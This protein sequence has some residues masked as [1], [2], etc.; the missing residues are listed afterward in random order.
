MTWEK[1]ERRRGSLKPEVTC[2]IKN[3][4]FGYTC[5]EMAQVTEEAKIELGVSAY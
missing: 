5:G 3:R 2:F 4:I 1:K